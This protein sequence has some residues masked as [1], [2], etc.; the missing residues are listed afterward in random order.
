MTSRATRTGYR[1][2]YGMFGSPYRLGLVL[3]M[4][5]DLADDRKAQLDYFRKNIKKAYKQI[6]P[7]IV[8]DG[9]IFENV[10]RG[11]DVDLA[12]FPVPI[13]HEHDGG[14]YIGTACGVVTKDPDTGRINVGTYRVMVKGKNTLASYIS[15]G[16]QGRI[17][18]DK[19]LKAGKPCPVAIIVG[20]DPIT[21]LAAAYTMADTR[22]GIRL[23]RRHDGPADGTRRRRSDRSAVSGA[24]GDR[25]R[26]L[27]P[28]RRN[29][30]RRPVRRVARLLRR[31]SARRAADHGRTRVLSHGSDSHVRREPEAAAFASLRA[32][33][34]AFGRVARLARRRR[35]SRRHGRVAASS[36]LGP[37]VLRRLDQTALLRPLHASRT[38]RI[39]G[40]S[41]RLHR[42]LDRRCRR[43]CRSDRH[44]RRDL[45]DGHALRS[46]DHDDRARSLLVVA[47]RHD[48]H[49]L[50]EAL[51]LAHG[52]RRLPPLR[53]AS[54]PFRPWR[55]VH[56]NSPPKCV[57]NT[58]N[59]YK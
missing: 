53:A 23:V 52:D 56:P 4:E 17:H 16:K 26:R 45:G 38:R 10:Q 37:H 5:A 46:E 41:G 21:Y 31:R 57:P 7:T 39:A 43:R 30:A 28:S 9:P 36:R 54:T 25:A 58:P 35:H 49:R 2:T 22:A 50:L 6:A 14:R 51:Q 3:G 1:C 29:D 32:L 24:R 44:P 42:A 20:I 8:N 11:D 55:R 40:E 47:S 48:G 19:Y 12:T 27:D 18:R 59:C 15:N 34:L 13:H 33:L